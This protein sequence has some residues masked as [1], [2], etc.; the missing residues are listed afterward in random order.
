MRGQKKL[1]AH[2]HEREVR[3]T[4]EIVDESQS[5]LRE[6]FRNDV[7]SPS[8]HAVVYPPG[9][10]DRAKLA[11]ARSVK[12]LS[13]TAVHCTACPSKKHREETL[14]RCY[15]QKVRESIPPEGDI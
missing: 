13:G 14:S 2:G 15:R 9:A 4:V 10:L 11:A 8:G 3:Y 1:R 7:R 5:L 6:P 12:H